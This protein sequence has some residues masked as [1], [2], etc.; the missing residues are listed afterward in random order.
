MAFTLGVG[1]TP[2]NN[3]TP[4]RNYLYDDLFY[5]QWVVEVALA[6]YEGS[7][8]HFVWTDLVS[9]F[10]HPNKQQILPVNITKE[11]IDTT[12]I[13]YRNDPIYQVTDENGKILKEDQKLWQELQEES[14]YLM[15]MDKLD[16]WT[17]LLG[18]VLTKVS[19]VDPKTGQ[20]VKKNNQGGILQLD[21]LHGGVYDIKYGASPY[22]ITELMIGFNSGFKGF[23]G[24][25]VTG[26]TIL[27]NA[28]GSGN[29]LSNSIN[30]ASSIGSVNKVY[31]SPNSHT[32]EGEN[33]SY[34]GKNPY[35]L[36]P[37]VPFFNQDPAYYYFL[38]INEPL[39]YA[40]HAINMRVTDLNHIAKFQSFG[41]PVIKGMERPTSLRQGRPTDDFNVLKGGNASSRFGAGNFSGMGATGAFRNFDA[42]LTGSRD[43][44][45]DANALGFSIG[46]DSAVA[47]GEKGDFRFEHPN[48]DINGLIKTIQALSD[49]VRV[50]HGLRPKYQDTLPASGFAMM[51][52]KM[53][54]LE[55][56]I[57]RGKLFAERE[58]QLFQVIKTLHNTHNQE[59]GKRRFSE[60]ARL[61]VTYTPPEF[62]VDP[63]TKLQT[64]I[65]EQSVWNSGDI[66]SVQKIHSHMNDTEVKKTMK[67][68]RKDMQEQAVHDN[69]LQIDL[70]KKQ[71][72]T[73]GTVLGTAKKEEKATKTPKPKIDNRIKHAEDSSKQP[74]KGGQKKTKVSN[75]E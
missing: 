48:A 6:F 24:A 45:A 27:A 60:N 70:Q 52:D 32:M 34:E 74:G 10:R 72:D 5:R 41:I 47:V 54:V 61:K 62:P 63:M 3:L 69:D 37:A 1:N 2:L 73:L 30:S 46:P 49:M 16:R 68:R 33:G 51:L 22:Y 13:L 56:N 25:A 57:R 64:I 43:G 44:N 23:K 19:F 11:I 20:L 15:F 59:R 8:D 67:Q 53:G 26:G 71:Q 36:I 35:G 50:S 38:P 14:R 17:K 65:T 42:G 55:E 31:W 66:Y 7:Q 75:N 12:S 21:M 9:Q 29:L 40:N 4:L 18:T 39:I 28:P 58:A